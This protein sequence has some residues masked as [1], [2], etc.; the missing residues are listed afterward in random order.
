MHAV[1]TSCP[2]APGHAL[3]RNLTSGSA[4]HVVGMPTRRA[5]RSRRSAPR[6]IRQTLRCTAGARVARYYDPQ[7]AQFLTRDPVEAMTRA[8]YSYAGSDPLDQSDPS[9]LCWGPDAICDA[10]SAVGSA[11]STAYHAAA[12]VVSAVARNPIA[13][14]AFIVGAC[15]FGSAVGCVAANGAVN[16][17]NAY[18][19]YNRDGGFTKS[20]FAGTAVDLVASAVQLRSIRS[21]NG[22]VHLQDALGNTVLRQ[23]VEGGDHL[24]WQF[25]TQ[26]LARNA[27]IA[28]ATGG[29]DYLIQQQLECN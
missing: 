26:I 24:P 28:A 2:R 7:T 13:Q 29:A 19:R 11:A 18:D 12:P 10:A 3:G 15:T 21:I 16:A 9:G 6:S 5:R 22:E 14:G 25:V 23:L 1:G 8:A 4:R 27:A 20:F 17:L